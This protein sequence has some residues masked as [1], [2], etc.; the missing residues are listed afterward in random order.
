MPAPRRNSQQFAIQ[1]LQTISQS[2]RWS[3]REQFPNVLKYS[4]LICLCLY[5]LPVTLKGKWN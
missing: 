3:A 5:H 2:D 1:Y 4:M